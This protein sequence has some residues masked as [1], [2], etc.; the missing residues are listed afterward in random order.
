MAG[1][2][3]LAVNMPAPIWHS[4][5]NLGTNAFSYENVHDV[6]DLFEPDNNDWL[7]IQSDGKKSEGTFS[8]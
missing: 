3:S 7:L 5:R 8:G 6:I 4:F 2:C 1:N